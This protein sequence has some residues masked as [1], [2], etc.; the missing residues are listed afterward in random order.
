MVATYIYVRTR[1]R[2]E[3]DVSGGQSVRASARCRP[4]RPRAHAETLKWSV[5][6][7]YSRDYPPGTKR[8]MRSRALR[9]NSELFNAA[10]SPSG[11][12]RKINRGDRPVL[13]I[14]KY[15]YGPFQ[16]GFLGFMRPAM[17]TLR[18]FFTLGARLRR[19]CGDL[20]V[21][22]VFRRCTHAGT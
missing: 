9:R 1:L 19:P 4:P 3:L 22:A 20:N 2:V 5:Y 7:R 11:H 18:V 10:R 8:A 6:L 21:D 17:P 15:E 13:V 16:K 14:L 12:F